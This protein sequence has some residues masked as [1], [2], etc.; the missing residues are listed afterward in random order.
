MI[1]EALDVLRVSG[2][3][4]QS[5][6]CP[7][8]RAVY[9]VG[10][11]IRR[12]VMA[13]YDKAAEQALDMPNRRLAAAAINALYPTSRHEAGEPCLTTHTTHTIS[14]ML[15]DTQKFTPAIRV[16]SPHV[17]MLV[18]ISVVTLIRPGQKGSIA[19]DHLI[20]ASPEGEGLLTITQI[21]RSAQ[22]EKTWDFRTVCLA[23]HLLDP[24][25][26]DHL[27]GNPFRSRNSYMLAA[28]QSIMAEQVYNTQL[29]S[30]NHVCLDYRK[31]D[32]WILE[33]V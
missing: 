6:V 32:P 27:E 7:L 18:S 5:P 12:A 30:T 3:F 4:V 11:D 20:Y 15:P 16:N 14:Y 19:C 28:L 26:P 8:W 1:P 24:P 23:G 31:Q 29:D 33:P 13:E 2:V 17:V 9:K 21:G 25:E 22:E 10:R